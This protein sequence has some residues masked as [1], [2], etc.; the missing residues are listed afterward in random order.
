MNSRVSRRLFLAGIPAVA[1]TGAAGL[2]ISQRPTSTGDTKKAPT[3][4]PLYS[5][6][7]VLAAGVSQRIPFAVVDDANATGLQD[8]D[9]VSV[10]VVRDGTVIDQLQVAGRV[11]EHDHVGED[12][13]PDHQHAELFRYYPLQAELPEPGIYDLEIDFGDVKSSMPVQVFDASEVGIVLP[14]TPMPAVVSATIDEPLDV[15]TLCTRFEGTCSFHED[16]VATL[17]QQ[18]KPLAVLIATPALCS[19]AYCGPVLELLIEAA[20]RY[21]AINIVH[22]EPYAN[23]AAVSNNFADPDIRLADSMAELGLEFEPSLFLVD[24]SGIVT[25]RIDNLFDASELDAALT[26]LSQS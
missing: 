18:A 1:A 24:E 4:V 5:S 19:T 10:K 11:V 9:A 23:S 16:S 21:P 7:R 26:R 15:D 2:Y 13:D 17:L 20:D 3:I 6:D 14:G 12:V 25:E 8:S 22:L